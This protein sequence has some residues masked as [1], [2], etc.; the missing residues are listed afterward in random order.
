MQESPSQLISSE[1][2][3]ERVCADG[4]FAV[5]AGVG[6]WKRPPFRIPRIC[7]FQTTAYGRRVGT[8]CRTRRDLRLLEP[9]GTCKVPSGILL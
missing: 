9:G 8:T 4:G 3:L 6:G 1:C 2:L 7:R 5:V